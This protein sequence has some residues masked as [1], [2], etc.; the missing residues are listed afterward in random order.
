MDATETR[1]YWCHPCFPD[2][3]LFKAR[4]TQHRYE[5][6]THPT[7][8]IA[9]ITS[10]CE[11][12]RIGRHS[13]VAPAGTIAVVNPEVWHDG[14]QGADEGWAYRTFYPSVPL[15]TAI[16][17]EV[18]GADA[19]VFSRPIIEDS[20]LAAAL[21][22]AHE[23]STSRDA[24]KAEASLLVALR[25]LIVRHG[26]WSGRTE[27]I[28]SS[29][30]RQRFSL[31]ED[32]VESELGSQLD[33]QRL[34]GAARVTRFQV[35]RDFKKAIGLTPAAYIRDRRLRRASSLIEQG[36]GLADAAIA[37]G[38]AD[39]SHLSRTFRATRGMTPGMYR[40]RG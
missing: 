23:G 35:I 12:I 10:G 34:A 11:R 1:K 39:Q 5:L 19:P 13:I 14:E 27:E 2:L 36:L 20:D 30:S 6:H 8:V 29:G 3:G 7:Y 32:L 15:M 18:G 33:L 31:Y 17:R 24:T 9:L 40:R 4:F 26:D 25:H 21:A 16:A 38:F 22:T 28:D 37:A